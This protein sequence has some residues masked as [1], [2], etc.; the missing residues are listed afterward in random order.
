MPED[1]SSPTPQRSRGRPSRKEAEIAPEGELLRLAL[2]VFADTGYEG[3]SIRQLTRQLG[4]RSFLSAQDFTGLQFN[5]D[6]DDLPQG[7]E[8][9]EELMAQNGTWMAAQDAVEM[10]GNLIRHIDERKIK[11]GFFNDDRE[12]V[13][14]ELEQSLVIAERANSVNGMFNF[15]VVM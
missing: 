4:V 11:F 10:L 14:Q 12:D 5:L 8:S 9:T 13:L 1:H 2:E 7:I 15:S 3:T 6:D